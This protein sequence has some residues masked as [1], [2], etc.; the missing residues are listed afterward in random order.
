MAAPI[1]RI[2]MQ[3]AVHAKLQTSAASGDNEASFVE[4]SY[5]KLYIKFIRYP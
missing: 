3:Q 1:G 2:L 4:V 5:F